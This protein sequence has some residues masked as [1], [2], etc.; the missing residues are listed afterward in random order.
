MG[1]WF[2]GY[3]SLLWNPGFEYAE[4]RRARLDHFQRSF[5]LYSKYHR[6]TPDQPGLVLSLTSV[7]KHFCE[8]LAFRVKKTKKYEVLS[9][10][11]KRELVSPAYI[12]SRVILDVEFIG[13][14][15]AIT[16]LVDKKHEQYCPNLMLIDKARIIAKAEGYSGKNTEYLFNTNTC[17]ERL[18]IIDSEIVCLSYLV[19]KLIKKHDY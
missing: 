12:E 19:K 7:D 18:K 13:K 5:S 1:I 10:L 3:G 16:Y 4:V 14:V 6:G 11:R 8:G 17:L 2:F 9:Y 15:E